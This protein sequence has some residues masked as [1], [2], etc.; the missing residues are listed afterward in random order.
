MKTL[1][2]AVLI[3]AAG[4]FFLVALAAK[5]FSRG[6]PPFDSFAGVIA[7]VLGIVGLRFFLVGLFTPDEQDPARSSFPKQPAPREPGSQSIRPG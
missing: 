5:D 7:F 1:T 2:G 6:G 4:V 3:T